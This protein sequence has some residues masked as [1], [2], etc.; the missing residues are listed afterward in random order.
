MNDWITL[1]ENFYNN[2]GVDFGLLY[3]RKTGDFQIKQKSVLGEFSSPGLA[4]LYENGGWTGDALRITGGSNPLFTYDSGDIFQSNPKETDIAKQLNTDARKQVYSA[5]QTLGG[6]NSGVKVNSAALPENQNGNASTTNAVSGSTPGVAGNIPALSNPPG[7]GNILD[8][9][10]PGLS[11]NP[12]FTP[13]PNPAV[14]EVLKYPIDLLETAQD[15]LHITQVEYQSPTQDIFS[16]NADI[17]SI[18]TQGIT[19]SGVSKKVLKGA[20]ILPVPNN[21][22]DSNN[23]AW[24]TDEMNSLTTAATSTVLNKLPETTAGLFGAKLAEALANIKGAGGAAAIA[25]GI[26]K[27]AM[28]AYLGS[29]AVGGGS[30]PENLIKASL[31]S[32]ILNKYGFEV[33]PESILARGLGVVPNSNLQLLFN[34]VTL[35]S[36]NFSYMMSPRSEGEATRVNKILRWFK[37]GMAAKKSNLQAGGAT[38]FLGTPNV[39]KLEYK[40]GNDP[41]KGMNKFKICALKG[42]SVNYAPNNQWSAYDGGQPTSVIMTMSFQEIEPIYD[43]DYQETNSDISFELPSVGP[44]DIG[45]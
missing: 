19:R 42:F 29:M 28:L 2:G 45:Y 23:V 38:L 44:E 40:S 17:A 1:K 7:S 6:T 4:V 14:G 10:S 25:G 20:V 34:N 16:G 8:L 30:E 43:T 33:S 18:V 24:T 12:D 32:F 5:F 39:F 11:P 9:F 13:L 26:P 41:I 3:N 35:R 37:Q 21:A 36:F 31:T 15:T 22:Q 27:A